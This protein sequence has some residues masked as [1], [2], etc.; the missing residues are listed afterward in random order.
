MKGIV[1]ISLHHLKS[2]ERVLKRRIGFGLF[3]FLILIWA[4]A[5]AQQKTSSEVIAIDVLILPDAVMKNNA[6]AVNAQLRQ[7]YPQGYALDDAHAPHVSMVQRF[8]Y[9]SDLDAVE[10]AVTKVLESGPAF[11]FSL[12]ANG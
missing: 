5:I 12:T 1:N 11:P 10:S 8:I 9:A 3:T 6:N 7:N 2:T 4:S